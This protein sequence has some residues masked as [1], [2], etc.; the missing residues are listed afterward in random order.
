MNVL[1]SIK[2]LL[3]ISF[4]CYACDEDTP[5]PINNN[6][7]VNCTY[8]EICL[9]SK[10]FAVTDIKELLG[11]WRFKGFVNDECNLEKSADHELDSILISF[12]EEN[13]IKGY[14]LPNSF[15]GMYEIRETQISLSNIVSTEINEPDWSKRFTEVFNKLQNFIVAQ[16]SLFITTSNEV[17]YFESTND[18]QIDSCLTCMYETICLDPTSYQNIN[19][20]EIIGEWLLMKYIN[21][22]DCSVEEK[23]DYLAETV[24]INFFDNDSISGNTPSNEFTAKFIIDKNQLAIRDIFSTEVNEPDW[25]MKFWNSVYDVSYTAI[26][27]ETLIIHAPNRILIFTKN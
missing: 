12:Q 11:T 7:C 10:E 24:K 13:L 26:S 16:N 6:E 2:L 15:E 5:T 14:I 8:N 4:L 22:P 21:L 17:L 20:E 1:K 9:D 19:K 18:L 27:G 23:P 25:G 3:L